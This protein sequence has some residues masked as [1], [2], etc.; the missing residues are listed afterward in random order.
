MNRDLP[1][2]PVNRN[3]G[4]WSRVVIAA[5]LLVAGTVPATA[6]DLD[7]RLDQLNSQIE[8]QK[9]VVE[10]ASTA[11]TDAVSALE[12]A[13]GE[14][15]AAESA[16]ATAEAELT[17]SQQLD[18][19]RQTELEAAE[20]AAVKAQEE[21]D[22]AQA[23]YDA[24]DARTVEEINVIA[25]QNG[26]L[27][28]LSLFL[29][30]D[31]E[32]SNI[33]NRAQLADTLFTSSAL[34]LDELTEL[35][36]KL[37]AAKTAADEAERVAAEARQAAADQLL[38]SQQAEAAAQT[39]RDNVAQLVATRDAAKQ[40]ADQQL[41]AEQQKQSD[42]E[43]EASGVETRIQERIAEEKRLEAE[44]LAQEQAAQEE[45]A[46][47]SSS[48][49]NSSSSGNSGNTGSSSNNSTNFSRPVAG[50]IT[51]NFGM[52]LHPVL[53]YRKLHDGTD[54]GAGCGTPIYAPA[55]GRV[56]ERY[57]NAGYGNRLMI[58]HGRVNG[59]YVTTGYNHASSYTVSV[60]E[61]VSKGQ[62]IGYVGT[63]GYSTGCH[64]HLMVWE[65][66]S[67]VNPM[68]RWFS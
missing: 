55:D 27:M 28:Q 22:A 64:L 65:N 13:Q 3:L 25:Q 63:T 39:Q 34:E 43:S 30:D 46:R 11:L 59:T 20:A 10:G 37:E 54:F 56:S 62:V 14:L 32:A 6:D 12:S 38:A 53:G 52:R 16:L 7:D 44:R 45:A 1:P 47:Q 35:R 33:N 41:T 23:A 26:G 21:V 15:T 18:A 2:Q 36:F 48:S 29:T 40:A 42:L 50:G 67:V 49:S 58:D 24:V 4:R 66:G 19:Q 57:F 61:Y 8:Q 68:A 51:S 60:G 31:F 9:T 17:A 5:A